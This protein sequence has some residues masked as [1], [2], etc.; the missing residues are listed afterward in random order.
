MK[1][2][3][4]TEEQLSNIRMALYLADYFVQDTKGGSQV[5]QWE[6]DKDTYQQALK[7]YNDIRG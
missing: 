5:E 6:T 3:T 1:T 4:I 7:T 2:Y